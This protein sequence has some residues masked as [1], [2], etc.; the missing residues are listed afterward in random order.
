M[1]DAPKI[2]GGLL[3]GTVAVAAVFSILYFGGALA[4]AITVGSFF[5]LA[6]VY[7]AYTFYTILRYRPTEPP[8]N[9]ATNQMDTELLEVG[10]FVV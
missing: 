7:F 3:L 5:L 10:G 9:D 4:A 1:D 8:I 2:L 6:V